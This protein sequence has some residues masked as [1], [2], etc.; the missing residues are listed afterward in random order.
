MQHTL[1]KINLD[2]SDSSVAFKGI[3]DQDLV[4]AFW[5]FR[6]MANPALSKLNNR[7]VPGLV[8]SFFPVRWAVKKTAFKHFCGGETI[9]ECEQT[10]TSLK[11]R[12]VHTILDYSVE[13]EKDEA[14]FEETTEEV[15]K[16]IEKAAKDS[17]VPFAV[18]K[19]SGLINPT[20]LTK[21]QNQD[22]LSL[23]ESKNFEAFIARLDSVFTKASSGQVRVFVDAEESWFQKEIDSLTLELMA[24]YNH[25]FP[26]VWNTYQL[27]LMHNRDLFA[28]HL[29]FA[30][31]KGFVLGAKLVR[32]AYMEKESAYAA[33]VGL[34]TPVN[35]SKQATDDLYNEVATLALNNIDKVHFCLGT[36][37]E[38]SCRLIANQM[39]GNNIDFSDERVWFAQL[40]G[41]SDN[42]SNTLA[43]KG[44]NVAKY[45]PYGPVKA[46]I[47]YLVRRAQENTS[48]AGQTSRELNLINAE[49]KRRGV[50]KAKFF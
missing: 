27:Y 43:E 11:A 40:L 46:V 3:N 19:M 38:D 16:T 23:E 30:K 9:E 48:V 2:F 26:I 7:L 42:L 49:L 36:H 24:K 12:L 47:P 44:F 29:E 8:K 15:L 41:M 31:A 35:S 45:V 4:K 18:F 20:I 37:N 50:S 13:G 21:R 39:A 25:S 1:H 17:S 28:R 5:L 34:P 10:I 22:S 14:T 33:S 6:L 32:G